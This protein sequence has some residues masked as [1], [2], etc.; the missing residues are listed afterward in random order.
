MNTCKTRIV[1]VAINAPIIV[2]VVGD[3]GS[4]IPAQFPQSNS[5]YYKLLPYLYKRN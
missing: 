2:V 1:V 3:V 4:F 5:S